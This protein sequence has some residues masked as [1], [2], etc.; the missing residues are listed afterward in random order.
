MIRAY[1]PSFRI[2]HFAKEFSIPELGFRLYRKQNDIVVSAEW[3]ESLG[4]FTIDYINDSPII[5]EWVRGQNLNVFLEY[6]L[7]VMSLYSVKQVKVGHHPYLIQWTDDSTKAIMKGHHEMD[8]I[9]FQEGNHD[10][11]FSET[12]FTNA[13]ENYKKL[14]T[15]YFAGERTRAYRSLQVFQSLMYEKYPEERMIACFR[16]IESFLGM[17]KESGKAHA[18]GFAERL[19][20]FVSNADRKI[21][22]E[23]YQ[24]RNNLF[25]MNDLFEKIEI[26]SSKKAVFINDLMFKLESLV[27]YLIQNIIFQETLFRTYFTTELQLFWTQFSTDKERSQVWEAG[28]FDWSLTKLQ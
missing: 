21:L 14:R 18:D 12:D 7:L 16:I 5:C 23:L 27:R 4:E 6:E 8:G 25:H 28:K 9:T 22:K 11:I 13:I 24:I 17:T 2:S 3:K 1:F 20:F 15:I 26:E 19:G 10:V